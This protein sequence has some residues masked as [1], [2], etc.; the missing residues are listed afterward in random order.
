MVRPIEDYCCG[1]SDEAYF[2][3]CGKKRPL[4]AQVHTA[5]PYLDSSTTEGPRRRVRLSIYWPFIWF[6][7]IWPLFIVP[8]VVGCVASF[9]RSFCRLWYLKKVAMFLA[10]HFCPLNYKTQEGGWWEDDS[11]Y[12]TGLSR[13]RTSL[14]C[15]PSSQV[16]LQY[17]PPCDLPFLNI[18]TS[19]Q[20]GLGWEI[21]SFCWP[22]RMT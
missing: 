5:I 19:C 20:E 7:T 10:M 11:P 16:P 21:M 17:N 1:S 22:H 18:K 4:P 13:M 6:H 8:R 3:A 12:T 2:W 14:L 15:S 9:R